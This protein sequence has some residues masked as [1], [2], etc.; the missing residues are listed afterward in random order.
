MPSVSPRSLRK[1]KIQP[2]KHRAVRIYKTLCSRVSVFID[3]HDANI[4]LASPLSN[5]RI[6]SVPAVNSAANKELQQANA[7]SN[8]WHTSQD[9]PNPRLPGQ[10]VLTPIVMT[11]ARVY[12]ES[13]FFH[14]FA[15]TNLFSLKKFYVCTH[16]KHEG[17][18]V[19]RM[20]ERIY[21]L[22]SFCG[23]F[24]TEL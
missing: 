13:L 12:R 11:E 18:K 20:N 5:K 17:V 2:S 19:L 15:I 22:Y 4:S 14:L 7:E 24:V 3:S 6:R 21:E 10:G 9:P 1:L 8:N 16:E 23:F